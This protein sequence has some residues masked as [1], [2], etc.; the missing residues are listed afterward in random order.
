MN[1]SSG[2]FLPL[3]ALRAYWASGM[4]PAAANAMVIVSCYVIAFA[5][6]LI[7][8]L[9]MMAYLRVRGVPLNS[10]TWLT[11][12]GGGVLFFAWFFSIGWFAWWEVKQP[13]LY[14][15]FDG[16]HAWLTVWI[17]PIPT[18]IL[19]VVVTVA[20][21]LAIQY[22][23]VLANNI[24]SL[25]ERAD[26]LWQPTAYAAAWPVLP[27]MFAFAASWVVW[28]SPPDDRP[29][30][31]WTALF[32]IVVAFAVLIGAVWWIDRRIS[33]GK[34]NTPTGWLLGGYYRWYSY[35][36]PARRGLPEEKR[37][38]FLARKYDPDDPI[39]KKLLEDYSEAYGA[40]L[41]VVREDFE[42]DH[43]FLSKLQWYAPYRWAIDSVFLALVVL[44]GGTSFWP[45]NAALAGLIVLV[46]ISLPFI[47]NWNMNMRVKLTIERIIAEEERAKAL[48]RE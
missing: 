23:A 5:A 28:L 40:A 34:P 32:W 13:E 15:L 45:T 11:L 24:I 35:Q 33:R 48:A 30:F 1:G 16:S 38:L 36:H 42:R 27:L 26:S 21:Y 3:D 20:N 17:G 7:G 39:S 19:V 37:K 46:G 10:H 47:E 41:A 6:M 9:L 12:I 8:Q 29:T 4:S 31:S 2:W 14:L 25:P 22:S 18:A 44:V 43:K